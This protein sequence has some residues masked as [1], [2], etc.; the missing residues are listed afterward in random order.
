MST[1]ECQVELEIARVERFLLQT[2]T[3]HAVEVLPFDLSHCSASGMSVCYEA[4]HPSAMKASVQGWTLHDARI[5]PRLIGV[6]GFAEFEG[7]TKRH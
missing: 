6:R 4:R 1:S 5:S 2:R 3:L 7:H